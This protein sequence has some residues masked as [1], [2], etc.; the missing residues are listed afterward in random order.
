M[1]VTIL[2]HGQAGAAP[3]DSLR[4][5]TAQGREDVS[6]AAHKLLAVTG[7]SHL[8]APALILYSE[9]LRT[10]QTAQIV[11]EK[12]PEASLQAADALVPGG[13][14]A[15]VDALLEHICTTENAVDHALLV[16]HQPLV[17]ELADYYLG[18]AGLIP[19]LSPGSLVTMEMEVPAYGCASLR[20]Q[21]MPPNYEAIR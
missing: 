16:S 15:E 21:L 3:Q 14:Q 19:P 5:L 20:F 6:L 18:Q 13:T 2:R 8:S 10:K 12:M 7:Q 4:T 9:W 1:I 11:A 17:S